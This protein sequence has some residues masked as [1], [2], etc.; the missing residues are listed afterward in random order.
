MRKIAIANQKG[1][2]G[3]TTV[4]VNLATAL[5][6]N[7]KKVLLVDLDPQ[8]NATSHLGVETDSG[9][10]DLF[11]S[12]KTLDDIL[13]ISNGLDLL[14]AGAG[15]TDLEIKWHYPD[16]ESNFRNL[17]KALNDIKDYDFIIVDSPPHLGVLTINALTYCDELIIPVKCDYFAL[18]GL[19]KLTGTI[20]MVK[21]GLNPT[22]R[23][24]GIVPTF[25]D[26]RTS[27]SH[28]VL[29]E[30]KKNLKNDITKTIIRINTALAEAP[31]YSKDIFNY[32]PRSHGAE[33]FKRL[34][35]EIIRKNYIRRKK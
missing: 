28:Y 2:V 25:F 11:L 16:P 18:E 4:A 19:S 15:M 10:E 12:G 8:Q 13:Y 7:K 29:D 24:T 26:V 5:G 14:P 27:I 31:A 33:D 34:A 32:Q 22:L 1:G 17:K 30:L 9:I 23:I 21:Q 6:L 20:D 3:K 35:K